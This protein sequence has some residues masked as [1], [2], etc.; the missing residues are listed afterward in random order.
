VC[1]GVA[2]GYVLASLPLFEAS[3]NM[4][5][6]QKVFHNAVFEKKQYDADTIMYYKQLLSWTAID[7]NPV[8][9]NSLDILQWYWAL[10]SWDVQSRIDALQSFQQTKE[11]IEN[12]MLLTDQKEL[13][14]M[15]ADQYQFTSDLEI[16]WRTSLCFASLEEAHTQLWIFL[17]YLDG[18]YN[19]IE[20]T[21]L[22]LVWIYQNP[23]IEDQTRQCIL[24]LVSSTKKKQVSLSKYKNIFEE[25][26]K[27]LALQF[28]KRIA[29]PGVCLDSQYVAIDDTV[30]DAKKQL[31]T[32]EQEVVFLQL[33]VQNN[34]IAVLMELCQQPPNSDTQQSQ[35]L[36]EL[37]QQLDQMQAS[38]PQQNLLENVPQ[39]WQDQW[40]EQWEQQWSDQNWESNWSQMNELTPREQDYA[41]QLQRD[42][43][44]WFDRVQDLQ[45]RNWYSSQTEL[46]NTFRSFDWYRQDFDQQ[47]SEKQQNQQSS[48]R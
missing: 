35:S 2:V 14:A 21:L 40:Q 22:W 1:S 18:L 32:T 38:E 31:Q 7:K 16:L 30:N 48:Q 36:N 47:A 4:Q 39:A 29:D 23:D 45:Q 44:Q 24:W 20:Q 13:Y 10:V 43:I 41:E 27:Q 6:Q 3:H 33:S 46:D 11:E 34:D 42:G 25:Q 28:E 17:Q 26:K 9:M 5:L 8:Y 15:L 12:A 19:L 37:Q